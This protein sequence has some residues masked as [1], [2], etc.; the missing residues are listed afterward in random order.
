MRTLHL[1][2]LGDSSGVGV[3]AGLDGGYPARL[4]RRLNRE[5]IPATLVNLA[6]SGATSADVVRHQAARLARSHADVVTLGIGGNDLWRLV[7]VAT[8]AENLERIADVVEAHA[9]R[10]WLV[11]GNIIDLSLAP[12]A[13]MAQ[14]FIGVGQELIHERVLE[15][16]H[17]VQA[18]AVRDRVTVVDLFAASRAELARGRHLFAD[19]GFHPSAQGYDRWAEL[20]WPAV[21]SA[22]R[23]R[24]SRRSAS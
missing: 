19:D 4:E 5:G 8:F 21:E 16:N 2:S 17:A 10:P 11:V 23:T 1:V 18:L 20:M 15:L 14:A 12:I 7:P 13:A 6:Q 3:G 9:E 24:A 22:S